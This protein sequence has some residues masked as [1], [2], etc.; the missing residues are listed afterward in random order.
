LS[1]VIVVTRLRLRDPR[2]RGEFLK[3][4]AA[5]IKQANG[6]AG[7]LGTGVLPEADDVYWTRTAWSDRDSMVVFMTAEPHLGMMGSLDE[8]C[9]EASFVEW[10]QSDPHMPEWPAAYDRLVSDGHSPTLSRPS[11]DHEARS[12][13]PVVGG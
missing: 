1:V 8:W 13:P 3:A 5:A 6:A 12:F 2:H 9:D 11:P 7:N 4:A 10:E